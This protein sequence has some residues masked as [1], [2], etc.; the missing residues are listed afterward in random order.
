MLF[1]CNLAGACE[2]SEGLQQPDFWGNRC[3]R[4]SWLLATLEQGPVR[5][6]PALDAETDHRYTE[7]ADHLR[8]IGDQLDM[9][10]SPRD[11]NLLQLFRRIWYEHFV[12]V[13]F[14]KTEEC[15]NMLVNWMTSVITGLRH[16]VIFTS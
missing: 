14:L 13:E 11:K 6:T 4:E 2:L 9:D 16:H 5:L 7:V 15:I 12:Q 1:D 10:I 3:P 8:L